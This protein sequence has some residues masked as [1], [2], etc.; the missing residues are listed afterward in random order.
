MNIRNILKISITLGIVAA[1]YI[2]IGN[3]FAEN[4]IN[5]SEYQKEVKTIT[6]KN[7]S[8]TKAFQE[9]M[10]AQNTPCEYII[11]KKDMYI[12]SPSCLLKNELPKIE[13]KEAIDYLWPYID[14]FNMVYNDVSQT[15]SYQWTSPIFKKNYEIIPKTLEE[16]IILT[17]FQNK[18]EKIRIHKSS[19]A[20]QTV[21][22]ANFYTV[23]K[24]TSILKRCTKKNYTIA[25]NKINGVILWSE[26]TLNLNKEIMKLKWYCKWAGA[27]DLL[28]YG[29]VCG[30]ATQLFRTSLLVPTIEITKRYPHNERLVPYY[31]DYVFWD[32]AALYEMNKQLEIKNT[33]KSDLYLKVLE[34]DNAN[35]FVIITP[36]KSNQWVTIK[37]SQGEWLKA[38]V[39]REIYQEK[40]DMLIKKDSFISTYIKKTYTTQ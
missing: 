20:Y 7:I 5:F 4:I 17:R 15:F 24:D 21:K 39:Q 25:L 11:E 13:F 32:D 1:T 12:I 37:K 38:E 31:S 16:K 14:S 40:T 36:E 3:T 6:I 9:I 35:Y 22:K 10:Q 18:W 29:W 23:Y 26:E 33:W 30:F 34:K 19:L 8:K 2:S 28:F 27:Q